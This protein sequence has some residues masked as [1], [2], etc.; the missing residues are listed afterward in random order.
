MG[1]SLLEQTEI[2]E[3]D[4]EAP[5][6]RSTYDVYRHHY[7]HFRLR[8]ST[9]LQCA[10]QQ[11]SPFLTDRLLAL[12]TINAHAGETTFYQSLHQERIHPE[13]KL[14]FRISSEPF[15]LPDQI[16]SSLDIYGK[17]ISEYYKVCDD[18]YQNLPFDHR[19]KQYLDHHKPDSLLEI[20]AKEQGQHIFLRPDFILTKDEPTVTEIETSPFGI[21]LSHFLNDAYNHAKKPT[22]TNPDVVL[23]EFIRSMGLDNEQGQSLCLILTEY[24]R[25]YE[26]QF[27]YLANA[28][29]TKGVNA[30]VQLLDNLS[31]QNGNIS[32][33]GKKFD[34]LY[35]GFYLHQALEDPK[36]ALLLEESQGRIYPVCKP[37]MEEKALMAMLWEE[38]FQ[39]YFQSK[40]GEQVDILKSIIPPTWVLDPHRV[41]AHM[42][43]GIR[44]WKDIAKLSRK[45]RSFVLKTSGFSPQS[46]WAKGV[47]FL[48]KLSQ[49]N[50]ESTIE[51]AL[52][53]EDDLFILQEFR[54]GA[55]F[56]HDYFDFHY[57]SM[58]Q[59]NG[60]I[61]FTPYFSVHDG[62]L[63][64]AKATMCENT[65]YVHAMV[66]SINVPVL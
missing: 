43:Y 58:K 57:A 11:R 14:P 63:L 12:E 18:L 62:S 42:P 8:L 31:I 13:S 3:N 1:Y 29:R 39:S 15:K 28:L 50:C 53:D 23:D 36:I 10:Q 54:K 64:T 60:R 2:S 49:A 20:S 9:T 30:E 24:T 46:S 33:G 45:Q 35:R 21:A 7:D 48:E 26:G 27:D 38:E 4:I 41:P 6:N 22:L 59:M 66:D 37:H 32:A 44:S 16:R 56:S 52:A 25:R 65:D 47:T 61:R 19:W 17:A 51:N 34:V 55:D 5:H 40:L